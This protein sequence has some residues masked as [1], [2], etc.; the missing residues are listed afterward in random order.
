MTSHTLHCGSVAAAILGAHVAVLLTVNLWPIAEYL[1]C[2]MLE[3]K[4][5]VSHGQSPPDGQAEGDR[6]TGRRPALL[7]SPLVCPETVSRPAVELLGACQAP[8]NTLPLRI[9][10]GLGPADR[11]PIMIAFRTP[12]AAAGPTLGSCV[13]SSMDMHGACQ[14]P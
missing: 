3:P 7:R 11:F 12:C 1:T 2:L 5:V 6:R 9:C 13:G 10:R 8:A 14:G 4:S